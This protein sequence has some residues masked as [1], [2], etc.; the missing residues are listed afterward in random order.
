LARLSAELLLLRA[1]VLAGSAVGLLHLWSAEL[2]RLSVGLLVLLRAGLSELAGLRLLRSAELLRRLVLRTGRAPRVGRPGDRRAAGRSVRGLRLTVLSG[3]REGLLVL[4]WS[5]VLSRLWLLRS[6]EWLLP[7]ARLAVLRLS[8]LSLRLS[9]VL[10]LTSIARLP[11]LTE[12]ALLRCAVL[13]SLSRLY[14]VL[15]LSVRLLRSRLS[16]LRGLSL[17]LRTVLRL[18]LLRTAELRLSSVTR[19]SLLLPRLTELSRLPVLRLSRLPLLL[20]SVE[21]RAL[22]RCARLLTSGTGPADGTPRKPRRLRF[23]PGPPQWRRTLVVL[24]GRDG[25]LGGRGLH[26]LLLGAAGFEP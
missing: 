13:R 6:A 10:R 24:E 18:A 21:L 19:L 15:L 16:E 20:R 9:A 25:P 22:R 23:R 7:L 14:A 11:R 4:L 17:G 3:L 1:A 12:L 2:S 5:S 8:R 26:G